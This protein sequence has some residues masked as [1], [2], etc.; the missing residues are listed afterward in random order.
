MMNVKLDIILNQDNA[1]VHQNE[2]II[3]M[4]LFYEKRLTRFVL[5][6]IKCFSRL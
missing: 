2:N 3:K 6:Y 4:H 5:L 1:C